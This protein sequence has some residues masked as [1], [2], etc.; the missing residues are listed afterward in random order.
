MKTTEIGVG[1]LN[2]MKIIRVR[3]RYRI[4]KYMYELQSVHLSLA[5]TTA[6]RKKAQ[7][8]RIDI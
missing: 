4:D 6:T 1:A 7:S 3:E 8:Q 2:Y 5:T